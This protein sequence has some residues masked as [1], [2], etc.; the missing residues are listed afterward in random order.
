MVV[1]DFSKL[2][3]SNLNVEML[4]VRNPCCA[5]KQTFDSW[6]PEADFYDGYFRGYFCLY[7]FLRH[8]FQDCNF[9]ITFIILTVDLT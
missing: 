7:I 9:C 1:D 5:L 6:H 8:S 2:I 3:C 4:S